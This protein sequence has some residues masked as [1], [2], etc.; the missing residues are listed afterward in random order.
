MKAVGFSPRGV[1]ALLV[2]EYLAIALAAGVLGPDRGRGDRAAA[3]AA[4]GERAGDAHA[5]RVRARS[6]CSPRSSLIL[7]AVAVFT[8]IPALRA[9]RV[10]TVAALALGRAG[11]ATKR[12]ARG[13]ARRGAPPSDHRPARRQGRVHEPLARDADGRRA[14]DHGHDARRRRSRREATFNRVIDDP[15]PAREALR[16][17]R[18]AGRDGAARRAGPGA[19]RPRRRARDDDHRPP[20]QRRP[21][22]RHRPGARGRRRLR[23]FAYAVPDGPHVRAPR[24]GDRR[25]RPV[26]RARRRRSATR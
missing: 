4:D 5:V 2:G 16:H 6:R 25:P 10:N 19:R 1:L 23:A 11:G 9:G 3:A 7:L 26:R 21:R 24:R 8:A 18:P 22:D 13:P 17:E 20:G 12:V 14:G 15:G